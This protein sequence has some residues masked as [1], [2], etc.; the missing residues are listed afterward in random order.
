MS[1]QD[2]ALYPDLTAAE[3]LSFLGR[4][5]RL[6]GPVLAERVAEALGLTDLTERRDER[7][8]SFSGGMKRRLNIAAGLL[9]HPTLLV[10]DE[11]TVPGS[12]GAPTSGDRRE[13]ILALSWNVACRYKSAGMTRILRPVMARGLITYHRRSPSGSQVATGNRRSR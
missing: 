10:L 4:L 9:H 12:R 7:V 5:Y 2:I 11:P 3:N 13:R 6:R 1:P 8:D